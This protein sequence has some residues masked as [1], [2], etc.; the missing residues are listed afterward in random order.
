MPDAST[1]M[2]PWHDPVVRIET[3]ALAVPF[4]RSLADSIYHRAA[5]HVPV[6]EIET[7]DGIVGTGVSGVWAGA[8]LLCATIDRY[9]APQLLGRA[10]DDVRGIWTRL[11]WSDIHW[12]GRA[13]VVH[14]AQ[15]MIDQALWDIASQRAGLPLWRLLGGHHADLDS[16]N[17]DGGWLNLTVDELVTDMTTIVEAGWSW[18]KMKVG[19]PDWREDIERVR[20]VRQALPDSVTLSVDV[21]QRWDLHTALTAAPRLEEL[22]VAWLEEPLHP[23]D[24]GAHRKLQA[25][26][27]IP[28]A[29]G[30]N[31]YSR[32]AFSSFI[33][34]D[35]VRIV[36]VDVTRVG[37]I[38]EWLEIAAEA[39]A[40]GL[41]V[42][43]HAGD[44]MVV[45]RHLVAATFAEQPAMI[46]WIPWTLAC[47]ED[48]AEVRRGRV[49]LPERPGASTRIRA[50]ARRDWSMPGVGSRVT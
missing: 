47:F 27:A 17:T 29:L 41:W 28:I 18:V 22:G 40:A 34:A 14:M 12:V 46:E 3:Y 50:E 8:D 24:V 16:Y 36:Q 48:P 9:F 30:E 7:A 20:A 19:K 43:P 5:W 37:G 39:A 31:L 42:V 35:A 11:Y 4:E 25:A 26:T 44:M 6:V 32:H 10:T 2:S 13:G 38:T 49:S 15:S 23:D 21:N 1:A 33:R 45:A